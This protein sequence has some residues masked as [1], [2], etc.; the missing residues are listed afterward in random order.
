[1]NRDMSEHEEDEHLKI[2][3]GRSNKDRDSNSEVSGNE[4][5]D[6]EG[7]SG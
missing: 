4:S 1:M 3:D 7:S 2:G 6:E 5:S